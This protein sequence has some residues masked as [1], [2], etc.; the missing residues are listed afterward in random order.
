[1]LKVS[2]MNI[3]FPPHKRVCFVHLVNVDNYGW[4]LNTRIQI[5]Q[6]LR[7]TLHIRNH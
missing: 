3:Y 5:T 7:G 4:S 2:G 6:K 1:M